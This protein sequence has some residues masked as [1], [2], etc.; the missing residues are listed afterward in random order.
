MQQDPADSGIS[1]I[2][3][4][5]PSYIG[6]FLRCFVRGPGDLPLVGRHSA[7]LQPLDRRNMV[8][9]DC[10]TFV[11]RR[12]VPLVELEF[13]D[14]VEWKVLSLTVSATPCR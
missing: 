2:R 8:V 14:R 11:R 6:C 1:Q 13:H 5:M 4:Y 12:D 3:L 10:R 9:A 7:T